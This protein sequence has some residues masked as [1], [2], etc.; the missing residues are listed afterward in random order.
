MV[1]EKWTRLLQCPHHLVDAFRRISE[2]ILHVVGVLDNLLQEFSKLCAI[3]F[4]DCSEVPLCS[5]EVQASLCL[6]I[7]KGSWSSSSEP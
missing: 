6:D 3:S 5:T 1:V 7:E 2:Q 4:L